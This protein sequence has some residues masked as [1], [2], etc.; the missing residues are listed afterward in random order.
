MLEISVS[1]TLHE[2]KFSHLELCHCACKIKTYIP[3][4]QSKGT[5]TSE[6][7]RRKVLNISYKSSFLSAEMVCRPL[8]MHNNMHVQIM[9]LL[10]K[11]YYWPADEILT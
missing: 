10:L 9:S 8:P 2:Q 7:D 5:Q 3:N 1:I 4:I 6:P 11:H